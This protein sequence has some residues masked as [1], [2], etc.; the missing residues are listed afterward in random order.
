MAK[1]VLLKSDVTL[2]DAEYKE[3]TV[4]SVSD[5]IYDTLVTEGIVEE[6]VA[7]KGKK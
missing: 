3:G 4:L 2:N 1:T 6:Y 7:P 5:E